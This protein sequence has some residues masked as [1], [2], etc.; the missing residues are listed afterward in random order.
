M[1]ILLIVISV[2]SATFSWAESCPVE[3]EYKRKVFPHWSTMGHLIYKK[4]TGE[5]VEGFQVG[6]LKKKYESIVESNGSFDWARSGLVP[7]RIEIR[8]LLLISKGKGVKVERDS[9]AKCR[10][11]SGEWVDEYTGV[12]ITNPMEIHVDHV[13]S[14]KDAWCSGS[15]KW[16]VEKR[17]SFAN[18]VKSDM[19][20]G[21]LVVTSIS[22]NTSKGAR[23]ITDWLPENDAYACKLI[24]KYVK[25]KKHWGLSFTDDQI[26]VIEDY[27]LDDVEY[28][29]GEEFE[30]VLSNAYDKGKVYGWNLDVTNIRD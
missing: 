12:S 17:E 22:T 11:S 27:H 6:E 23:S 25:V 29:D 9:T 14:L 15:E 2:F 13:V 4:S 30:C 16:N 10:I 24:N 19:G 5:I 3:Q 21:N 26:D 1:R 7:C 28:P 8:E 20:P 18:S